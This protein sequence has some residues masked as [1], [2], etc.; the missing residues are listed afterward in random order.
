MWRP[1]WWPFQFGFHQSIQIGGTI[2]AGIGSFDPSLSDAI[3]VNGDSLPVVHP[4]PT[5]TPVH[6]TCGL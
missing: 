6:R 2:Y 1:R 5:L 4:C 3:F